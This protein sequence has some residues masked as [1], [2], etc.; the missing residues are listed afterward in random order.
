M[1]S[2]VST[3]AKLRRPPSV[4]VSQSVSGA[5]TI[6]ATTAHTI[7]PKKGAMS[8]AKTSDTMMR[9]ARKN[10]RSSEKPRESGAIMPSPDARLRHAP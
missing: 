8:Q 5:N 4:A 10:P 6:A 3:V 1:T 2:S 9:N 7:A